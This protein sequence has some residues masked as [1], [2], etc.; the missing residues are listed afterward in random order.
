MEPPSGVVFNSVLLNRYRT[1]KDSVSWHADDEPEFGERPVIASVSF[2]GTTVLPAQA[3]DAEG[4]EGERR[5]DARQP[6]HHARRHAGELAA[7]DP[8]DSEAGRGAAE[9]HVPRGCCSGP[10]GFTARGDMRS[11]PATSRTSDAP[12]RHFRAAGS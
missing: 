12:A 10:V 11:G 4:S 6:A 2:G 9:P 3:Q 7:P 5:A 8:E 1:G